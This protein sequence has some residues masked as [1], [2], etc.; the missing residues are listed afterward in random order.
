MHF[1]GE[2]VPFTDVQQGQKWNCLELE[3]RKG[4]K[5]ETEILSRLFLGV[6]IT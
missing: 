2:L 6:Q 5:T 1:K 4:Q 3:E